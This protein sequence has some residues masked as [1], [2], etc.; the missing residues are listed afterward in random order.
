M[1]AAQHDEITEPSSPSGEGD[2]LPV[3][4]VA[5][6]E[7]AETAGSGS[8]GPP[9][10]GGGLTPEQPLPSAAA[11]SHSAAVTL[12]AALPH[13]P[14][15]HEARLDPSHVS[16]PMTTANGQPDAADRTQPRQSSRPPA[17]M[18]L[19]PLRPADAP[20]AW[21]D[22]SSV[23]ASSLSAAAPEPVAADTKA[24][25]RIPEPPALAAHMV[26]L[27][28]AEEVERSLLTGTHSLF[29]LNSLCSG[30][31]PVIFRLFQA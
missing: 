18:Q 21:L 14:L 5:A 10:A 4:I 20:P 6:T 3:N 25:L 24:V 23:R 19:P 28:E 13:Q 9:A 26:A 17:D 1:S 2:Q 15:K 16:I 11:D 31:C 12:P 27:A 22:G 8:D 7:V 30:S 29:D